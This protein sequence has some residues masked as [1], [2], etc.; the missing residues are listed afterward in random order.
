MKLT[1]IVEKLKNELPELNWYDNEYWFGSTY[2]CATIRIDKDD[3]YLDMSLQVK[4]RIAELLLKHRLISDVE[5]FKKNT[6]NISNEDDYDDDVISFDS[7]DETTFDLIIKGLKY[8]KEFIDDLRKSNF[9]ED[10]LILI[11]TDWDIESSFKNDFKVIVENIDDSW[12]AFD[13]GVMSTKEWDFGNDELCTELNENSGDCFGIGVDNE[14][15]LED[16]SKTYEKL[17]EQY[18]DVTKIPESRIYWTDFD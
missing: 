16:L 14:D 10:Q 8:W 1:E 2:A 3:L 4:R 15:C 6:L 11:H 7:M 9:D 12:G 5:D 18:P 17:K 13:L